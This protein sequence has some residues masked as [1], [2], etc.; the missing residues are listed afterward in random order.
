MPATRARWGAAAALLALAAQAQ[1]GEFTYILPPGWYD[2]TNG[3]PRN[4]PIPAF[5]LQDAASG[6]YARVAIDPKGTTLEKVG[7]TFNAV[8]SPTTGH[9]TSDLANKAGLALLTTLR[10]SKV[11]ANLVSTSVVSMNGV[12]TGVLTLDVLAPDGWRRIRQYIIPGHK[13]TAVLTYGAPKD[14]FDKSTKVFE[15][16]ARG[17]KGGYD[18]G[19]FHWG[20]VFKSGA[21]AGA[22]AGIAGAIVAWVRKRRV[23]AD[24]PPEPAAV[25][26]GAPPA[27]TPQRRAVK[28]LWYCDQCGN[29]VPSRIDTC[30]CGGKRPA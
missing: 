25:A 8:E 19:V 18:P 3:A 15:T 2:I 16:A 30:R 23:A 14:D 26:A 29:P 4:E 12:D 6:R 20:E 10:S 13:T 17:T 22:V 5:V 1:A 28:G 27:K 11:A 9:L 7:A 21:I 24:A